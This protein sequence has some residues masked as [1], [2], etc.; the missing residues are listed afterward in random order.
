MRL[1]LLSAVVFSLLATTA[2]AGPG[3]VSDGKPQRK[4]AQVGWS[5]DVIKLFVQGIVADKAG[6]LS[7]A[8]NRYLDAIRKAPQANTY[9]NLADVYRRMENVDG[10]LKAYQKYLELAPDA[11]DRKA[12]EQLLAALPLVDHIAVIDGS[13]DDDD[14]TALVAIDGKIVG[15][16][17]QLVR[18]PPGPHAADRITLTG[19]RHGTFDAKPGEHDHL[20]L[21]PWDPRGERTP[22]GMKVI[23]STS[24]HFN[25]SGSWKDQDTGLDWQFPGRNLL[26]P[27]HYKTMPWNDNR[28]CQPIE[29]DVPKLGANEVLYVYVDAAPKKQGGGCQDIVTKT[30]KLTVAP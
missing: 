26:G 10:A 27:G 24:A 4:P 6:D 18:M 11:P 29:F 25:T 12:V 8:A 17:P 15:P 16:S 13:Y 30:Q 22:K 19:F 28:A 1:S 9:Y 3:F 2:T 23:L 14:G 7:R 21:P 5:D 20:T